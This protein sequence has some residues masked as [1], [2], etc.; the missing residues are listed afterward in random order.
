MILNADGMITV[1]VSL[2]LK[3]EEQAASFPFLSDQ[4]FLLPILHDGLVLQLLERDFVL[5][6]SELYVY[7]L[8]LFIEDA[9]SLP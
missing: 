2:L 7:I 8:Q 3:V 9:T 1:F 4:T 6:W 5:P